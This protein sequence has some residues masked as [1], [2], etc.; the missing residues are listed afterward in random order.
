MKIVEKNENKFDEE[1]VNF[2]RLFLIFKKRIKL[3]SYSYIC[4]FLVLFISG[5]FIK[6]FSPNYIGNFAMLISD[7]MDAKS[8]VQKN[9]TISNF[10]EIAINKTKNDIPTLI[11]L[12][13]S[14]LYLSKVAKKYKL[15][16]QNLKNRLDLKVGSVQSSNVKSKFD[17][18]EGIISVKFKAING[19]KDLALLEDISKSFLEA[20]IE[21]RQEQLQSG[22]VFLEKQEPFLKKRVGLIQEEISKFRIKNNLIEPILDAQLIKDQLKSLQKN[23]SLLQNQKGRLL[24]AK[25]QILNGELI[26]SSF[27]EIIGERT[28]DGKG[29]LVLADKNENILNEFDSVNRELSIA[30]SK[31]TKESKI[32]KGLE[33]RIKTL[34]PYLLEKQVNA[35]DNALKLNE[36]KILNNNIQIDLLKNKF[37]KKPK[38]IKKY[39]NL[40]QELKLANLNLEG[41]SAA[42]ESFKLQ[43]AQSSVPWKLIDKPNIVLNSSTS[44]LNDKLPFVLLI[45][46]L[47]SYL[48]I[49]LRQIIANKYLSPDEFSKDSKINVLGETAYLE[50]LN[51][52]SYNNIFEIFKSNDK[53]TENLN[54]ESSKL[55]KFAFKEVLRNIAIY[56]IHLSE[57]D[58][59]KKLIFNSPISYQGKTKIILLLAQTLTELG[60]KVLIIDLDLDKPDLH[61]YLG[62][63]NDKGFG[64]FLNDENILVNDI[65]EEVKECKNLFFISSGKKNDNQIN[66][67][68]FEKFIENIDEKNEY[69]FI[70]FDS[71]PLFGSTDS[72]IIS[73]LV[74]ANVLLFNLDDVNKNILN[75]SIKI[76]EELDIKTIGAILNRKNQKIQNNFLNYKIYFNYLNNIFQ[77]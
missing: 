45:S 77:K 41:I 38:L 59:Q 74:D 37:I 9:Y 64:N 53:E 32:V 40:M 43:I 20:S 44:N 67:S 8:G 21:Q 50:K 73:R 31:Y 2:E 63:S 60:K 36:N 54:N 55:T 69:D 49:Y 27:Q 10:E 7:P 65:T 13:K 57:I 71:P 48:I 5:K 30:R 24:S 42:K 61:K 15:S 46:F 51:N 17:R 1:L 68:Y 75:N 58:N 62:L 14:E 22:L 25:S 29:G 76:L 26:T 33:D 18:A 28:N 4:I 23:L 19:K 12:L 70:L 6:N 56:I 66:S 11:L 3:F 34:K 39:E 52:S 72:K 47:L 35:V 16:Y